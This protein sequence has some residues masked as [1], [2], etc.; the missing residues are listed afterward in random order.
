MDSDVVFPAYLEQNAVKIFKIE[1]SIVNAFIVDFSFA[2]NS[3][4]N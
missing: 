4:S 1:F 3:I 2:A